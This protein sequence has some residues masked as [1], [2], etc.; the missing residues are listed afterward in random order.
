[1][2]PARVDSLRVVLYNLFR[3]ILWTLPAVLWRVVSAVRSALAQPIL[4]TPQLQ[5][6]PGYEIARQNLEACVE[7]RKLPDGSEK[8]IVCAGFRNFREP[9]ARDFAFA[10]FGLLAIG[11]RRTVRDGLDV[12][13]RFQTPEGQF[14]LKV[15]STHVVY[16]YLHS[17]LSR[18]Q[19]TEQPLKPKYISAHRTL[20]ADGNLL[21]TVAFAHYVRE[22]GDLEYARRHLDNFERAVAWVERFLT[23]S[24]LIRQGPFSDWADSIGR[25]GVVHYTNVLYWRAVEQLEYLRRRLELDAK[26][27]PVHLAHL[28]NEHFWSEENGYYLTTKTLPMLNSD[29]NLLAVAWGLADEEKSS[30]V[31]EVMEEKGMGDP[32]P[33]RVTDRAYPTFLVGLEMRVARVP[34]YHTSCSWMWLGGWHVAASLAAGQ[35][36]RAARLM[37]RLER[38]IEHDGVVY[39]VHDPVGKPLAT[40]L[41]RSEAP[42]SWNAGMVCYAHHLMNGED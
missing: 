13:L 14:P 18:H 35:R 26:R 9:W 41:Y 38:V 37:R 15:H 22:T 11:N 27:D 3:I 25:S 6:L 19:P 24:G 34:H 12:F 36:E 1:M 5:G 30:R 32:V 2:G 40:M 29:G 42:L 23:P 8:E 21:L 17:L 28:V 4:V 20:S 33:T 7:L 39:E 31:L 10:S 16:R